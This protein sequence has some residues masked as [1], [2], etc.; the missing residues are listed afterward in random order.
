MIPIPEAILPLSLYIGLT[1]MVPRHI[2]Q[3]CVA[4]LC[5]S[6]GVLLNDRAVRRRG[7]IIFG[8]LRST[9]RIP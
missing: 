3:A 1:N 5:G 9:K 8:G 4:F 6:A 7:D 2:A